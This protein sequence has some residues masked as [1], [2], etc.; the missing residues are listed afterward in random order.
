MIHWK[1]IFGK[2]NWYS[3]KEYEIHYDISNNIYYTLC[4]E[5]DFCLNCGKKKRR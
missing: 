3:Y 5:S 1:C 4:F 2:H